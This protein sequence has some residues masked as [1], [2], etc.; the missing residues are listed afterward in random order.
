MEKKLPIVIDDVTKSK[1]VRCYD[2]R[3]ASEQYSNIAGLLAGFSFTVLMLVA[4]SN[5]SSLPELDYLR[6]NF[7]AVG[8]FVA[9]FGSIVSS[10]VFAVI[11]GEEALT[12]RANNMAFF[13]GAG[14]SLTLALTF[15]SI[16]AILRGFL[17]NEVANLAD[18]ILPLFM[19]IHPIYVTSSVLDNIYIF[20]RRDPILSE[21][22]LSTGLSLMP[23]IT[24]IGI[25]LIGFRIW[26]VDNLYFFYSIIWIFLIMIVIDNCI[27]ALF[28]T[29]DEYTHL[30]IIFC[31]IWM[32]VNTAIIS[33]LLLIL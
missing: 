20:K 23:I 22:L 19:L 11:S 31:G 9:F 2:V 24:A 8:F 3:K 10:F 1:R 30:N 7:A 12:P 28:S 17:V 29:A 15:W 5:D 14:F 27:A 25:R 6:R 13:G 26:I 4:Q 32:S 16:S 33:F 21:Y 18:Q